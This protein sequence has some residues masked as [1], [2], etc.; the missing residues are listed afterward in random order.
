[1]FGPNITHIRPG[2]HGQCFFDKVGLSHKNVFV[3]ETCPW[4]QGLSDFGAKILLISDFWV[5]ILLISD[6][7]GI[8][9]DTLMYVTW[10]SGV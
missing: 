6:F 3:K 9:F 8:P 1:M 4:K 5:K 7:R 2:F 10:A